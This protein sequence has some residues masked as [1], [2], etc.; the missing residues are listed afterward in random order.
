M[1]EGGQAQNGKNFCLP[2]ADL[3]WQHPQAFG[4]VIHLRTDRADLE[5]D[6]LITL[7]SQK[8]IENYSAKLVSKNMT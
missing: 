2:C 1:G 5:P 7:L 6:K 4:L 3:A 8:R